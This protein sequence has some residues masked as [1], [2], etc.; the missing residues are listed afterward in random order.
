VL[1]AFLLEKQPVVAV[2]YDPISKEMFY[3]TKG[4]GAFLASPR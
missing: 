1:I 2:T 3:A 4:G